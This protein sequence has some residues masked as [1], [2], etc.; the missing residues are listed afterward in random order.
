[1]TLLL[2]LIELSLELR[3]HLVVSLLGFFQVKSDLMDIGKSVEILVL[4]VRHIR[5]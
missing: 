5:L 1:M 3:G 2:L 4:I